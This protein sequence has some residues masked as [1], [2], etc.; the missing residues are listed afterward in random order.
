[1]YGV[2]W[3][4]YYSDIDMHAFFVNVNAHKHTHTNRNKHNE[5]EKKIEN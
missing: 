1:M 4:R 3:D 5:R 2:G